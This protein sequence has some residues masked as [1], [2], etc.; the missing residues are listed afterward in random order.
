MVPASSSP[1]DAIIFI[2]GSA[3]FIE[4]LG[5]ADHRTATAFVA[6]VVVSFA[7]TTLDSATRLLRFNISEMGESLGWR[8]LDNDGVNLLCGLAAG[9]VAWGLLGLV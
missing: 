9:L 4:A 7:L 2:T 5:V 1:S 6:V 3:H 8:W